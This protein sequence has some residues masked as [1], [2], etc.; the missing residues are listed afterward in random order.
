MI[1]MPKVM[2]GS[3]VATDLN[4]ARPTPRSATTVD[5]QS[6]GNRSTAFMNSTRQ[7][8]VIASG[9]ISGL[10]TCMLSLT[11]LSTITTTPSAYFWKPVGTLS[12]DRLPVRTAIA[13][14]PRNSSPIRADQNRLSRLSVQNEFGP[15][16]Q[17]QFV[18]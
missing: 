12:T 14:L 5:H 7:K 1:A 10:E 3:V 16:C 11:L 18:R 2:F 4:C 8:M 6:T 15:N 17:L 13:K 9:A